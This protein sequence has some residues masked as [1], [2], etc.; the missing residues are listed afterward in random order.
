MVDCRRALL[1][2]HAHLGLL[3]G[4]DDAHV[5]AVVGIA[6]LLQLLAVR[7]RC[8]DDGHLIGR[9][10]QVLHN[11]AGQLSVLALLFG[12]NDLL[13]AA[14]ELRLHVRQQ[15][16]VLGR[17]RMAGVIDA[18][19]WKQADNGVFVVLRGDVG[20]GIAGNGVVGRLRQFHRHL[21]AGLLVQHLVADGRR[22]GRDQRVDLGLVGL[23]EQERHFPVV[24][25]HVRG[26]P[27][28]VP[29]HGE[30]RAGLTALDL[31]R[32]A[33]VLRFVAQIG[34][35]DFLRAAHRGL[36][37]HF[38]RIRQAQNIAVRI[39]ARSVAHERVAVEQGAERIQ[40][41]EAG[42]AF[43]VHHLAG[44]ADLLNILNHAELAHEIV[45]GVDAQA[46]KLCGVDN[47]TQHIENLDGAVGYRRSRQA[48]HALAIVLLAQP[49]ALHRHVPGALARGRVRQIG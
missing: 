10:R 25:V 5:A 49:S 23:L 36:G 18:E 9:H 27:V 39:H 30:H 43:N 2:V 38:D 14:V 4:D 34:V 32:V 42:Q 37:H 22:Q 8:V 29:D 6:D 46:L 26:D 47:Q 21:F 3:V 11:Q 1:Q 12:E 17:Q 24:Q 15:L 19:T 35:A 40:V 7:G 33:G 45:R 16:G 31:L 28:H 48:D 44:H 13:A 20:Q 41:L